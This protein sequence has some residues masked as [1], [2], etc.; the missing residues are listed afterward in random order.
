[1]SKP[2]ITVDAMLHAPI[3]KVWEQWNSPEH[4]KQWCYASDDWHAP[5]A[6]NDLKKG[7]KFITRMEAKDKSF[8]FDFG[9]V[10][11]DVDQHKRIAYT[12][13]DGRKVHITF[14]ETDGGVKISE[15]FEAEDQN[16]LEMQQGGWQ[17][18][19]N[20]FKKYVESN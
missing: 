1:M 14:T 5:E 16:P 19:L 11:D 7:G 10:Y 4:I 9:G 18:I 8:G 2:V 6:T 17:M 13:D 3:A 15:S 12:M 20:N